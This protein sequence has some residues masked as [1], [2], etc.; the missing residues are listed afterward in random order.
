VDT[1]DNQFIVKA[2]VDAV[3]YRV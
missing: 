2:L 1:S 3:R